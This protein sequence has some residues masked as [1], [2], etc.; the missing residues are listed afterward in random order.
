MIYLLVMFQLNLLYNY[1]IFKT[2]EIYKTELKQGPNPH[3]NQILK[4]PYDPGEGQNAYI[5][6]KVFIN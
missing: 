5:V 4:I 1:N 2:D 3:W 6:E